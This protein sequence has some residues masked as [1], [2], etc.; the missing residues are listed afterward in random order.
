MTQ[1]IKGTGPQT[2]DLGTELNGNHGVGVRGSVIATMEAFATEFATSKLASGWQ[3]LP[4][5]IILQWGTIGQS[6]AASISNSLPVTL[7]F[8]YPNAH[9]MALATLRTAATGSR[10]VQIVTQPTNV[11]TLTIFADSSAAQ[12]VGYNWLS[13]GH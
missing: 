1:L 3:K 5:G 12:V 9:L 7:P 11:A 13:I 2:F 10:S 6:V 8:A 4:S